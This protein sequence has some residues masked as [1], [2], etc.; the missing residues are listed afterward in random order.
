MTIADAL[1]IAHHQID[2][3]QSEKR[4]LRE[5]LASVQ[6]EIWSHWMKYLFSQC[7]YPTGGALI[8]GDK[9]ERWSKQMNTPY[10]KLSE[11]EKESDREQAD[12]V[13]GLL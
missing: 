1:I 7:S 12:K 4:E 13:L 2:E 5:E 6:H 10:D 8:P 3:A 9:V 11:Q